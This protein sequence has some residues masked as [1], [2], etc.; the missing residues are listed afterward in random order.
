M[1]PGA[2]VG[3]VYRVTLNNVGQVLTGVTTR[4]RYVRPSED[5]RRPHWQ[6]EHHLTRTLIEAD[7]AGARAKK[8]SADAIYPLHWR[9][10][11]VILY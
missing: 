6:A 9:P 4:P 3:C 2:A 7:R 5:E 8:E 1:T 11:P 10:H